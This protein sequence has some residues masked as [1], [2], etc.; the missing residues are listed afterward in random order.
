MALL[1]AQSM[2]LT[3]LRTSPLFREL[4]VDICQPKLP[5][6]L[7][8]LVP[9]LLLKHWFS[10]HN[11]HSEG[12]C[13]QILFVSTGKLGGS[14]HLNDP[15]DK[16][17]EP[18]G[19][20]LPG[21]VLPFSLEFARSRETR[22]LFGSVCARENTNNNFSNDS[23]SFLF[24]L[25]IWGTSL[26]GQQIRGR[27]SRGR[28]STGRDWLDSLFSP[29][30]FFTWRRQT[31][32]WQ[33]CRTILGSDIATEDLDYTLSDG[34]AFLSRTRALGTVSQLRFQDVTA[35]Q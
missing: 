1:R 9:V 7:K 4:D 5:A 10:A 29:Q 33:G 16:K 27:P 13:T 20:K 28:G 19:Q 14:S 25:R 15:R 21:F 26:S 34:G 12:F 31:S 17:T 24:I 30:M 6:L 35:L 23:S 3:E 2:R 8:Q 11:F 22:R 32:K 18:F